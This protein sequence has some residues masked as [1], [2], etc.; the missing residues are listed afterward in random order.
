MSQG[1]SAAYRL[2][3]AALRSKVGLNEWLDTHA[4][5]SWWVF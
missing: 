1:F 5:N 2:N 4:S 3:L